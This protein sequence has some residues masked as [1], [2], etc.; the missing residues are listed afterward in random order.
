M[1]GTGLRV[2]VIGAGIAGLAAGLAFARAGHS[3]CL[4]ERDGAPPPPRP[5]QSFLDWERPGVPQRRLVHGFLP[6]ARKVLRTHLPDVVD[7]LFEAGAHDVDLLEPLAGR[8]KEPGDGE[9]FALRCRR[10]VFEWVLR[11]A[12]GA[13]PRIQIAAGE[14]AI[15]L[16]AEPGATPAVTG[17]RLRS[18]GLVAADLVVDAGG[19][20][21]RA[22][23]WLA[24][25]GAR[26]PEEESADCNLMYY[27][28]FYER[29]ED[30]F[31]VAHQ[32]GLGYVYAAAVAADGRSFSLT[33]FARTEEPG[34]RQLREEAA[35]ERA[36]AAIPGFAPW[37]EGASPLGPVSSMGSLQ[38]RVRRFAARGRLAVTGLIPVG[39]SI[40]HTN[41]TLG[42]GMSL[43]L[44]HA[45]KAAAMPWREA[46]L[47]EAALRF[48]SEVDPMAEASYADAVDA[49]RVSRLLYLN[50]P[51]LH[52]EP[53]GV[54][55]LARP[56]AARHDHA[57]YRAS[58]R[59]NGLLTPPGEFI[60]EP[61]VGRAKALLAAAPPSPP[62]GPD[63]DRMLELLA[64]PNAAAGP[65][66]R[67]D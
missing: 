37:R 9:L 17:V 57:L 58:V 46:G 40:S 14:T 10:T 19:R 1:A 18:G 66:A 34:L 11:S 6:L 15:G 16:S 64:A 8:T 32:A 26:P 2:V 20:Q 31:P 38:N 49:D 28:R 23:R 44:D 33:F 56:L 59:N 63:R 54:L 36:V 42:R 22:G 47:E 43:A 67:W 5:E 55:T 4:V 60:G 21:S 50:D 30:G 29:P 51:S 48:H 39:D 62:A 25:I 52:S 45:F 35:F 12:V 13:D 65:G 27:T 61:W 24:E 53:R 7:R 41:P 3:V